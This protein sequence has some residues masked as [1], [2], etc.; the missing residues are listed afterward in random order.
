MSESRVLGG[1]LAACLLAGP[2]AGVG[3]AEAPSTGSR[4]ARFAGLHGTARPE[5]WQ[6]SEFEYSRGGKP[7][8]W[9]R[10]GHWPEAPDVPFRGN[11][12]YL[13]GLADS[14]RNHAPLFSAVARSGWRVVSFD[15]LGQ[16]GSTGSMNRMRMAS[17]LELATTVLGKAGRRAP[18]SKTVVLGWSTGG[19]AAY[20]WARRGGI[21]GAIL[22][23]PGLSIRPI[24]GEHGKITLESLTSRVDPPGQDA[25]LEPIRPDSPFKVPLL[26]ADLFRTSLASRAWKV[27]PQVPGL[28]LLTGRLDTFVDG[29]GSETVLR[30][31]APHFSVVH[32][33]DSRHEPDN[34]VD[35]IRTRVIDSVRAFLAGLE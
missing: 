23:A 20:D 24:V 15:Y 31:G 22:M 1:I 28:A 4:I 25:H 6:L 18:G 16:G 17:I 33:E 8:G 19:L 26:A 9:I 34:E 30:R 5:A 32:L 35:P 13:E 3:R 2:A 7:L 27:S 12:V 10:Y 14:M 11:L 29:P 21:D